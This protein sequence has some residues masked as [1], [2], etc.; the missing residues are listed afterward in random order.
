MILPSAVN[1]TS[2]IIVAIAISV[3]TTITTVMRLKACDSWNCMES[4]LLGESQFTCVK[5]GLARAV[6]CSEVDCFLY[7]LVHGIALSSLQSGRLL[8]LWGRI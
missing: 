4:L 6:F 8:S 2:A 1:F 7:H 5:S 3:L